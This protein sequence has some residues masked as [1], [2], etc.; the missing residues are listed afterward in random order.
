MGK[1]SKTEEIQAEFIDPDIPR[2][3]LISIDEKF[4]LKTSNSILNNRTDESKLKIMILNKLRD[5]L[6][7]IWTEFE[8]SYN[9]TKI[10]ENDSNN[11][12]LVNKLT[13][14]LV[15]LMLPEKFK[16]GN[17]IKIIIDTVGESE[18]LKVK[19]DPTYFSLKIRAKIPIYITDKNKS[20]R[21]INQAIKT[22]LLSNN[23]LQKIYNCVIDY[24]KKIIIT[25][26]D[27]YLNFFGFFIKVL[28]FNKNELNEFE[29]SQ[30]TFEFINK[31]LSSFDTFMDLELANRIKNQIM[32]F[33][34]DVKKL[35]QKFSWY[36]E[37]KEKVNLQ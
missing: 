13:A 33:F 31:F 3:L 1:K 9:N 37:I 20:F 26:D 27:F 21:K 28:H 14:E 11:P 29:L 32:T 22:E 34:N 25:P 30:R 8:L 7:D 36:D 12:Y 19:Q 35:S 17:K 18:N 6:E 15:Q 4:L 16:E 23:I 2:F 24:D 10:F 5:Y